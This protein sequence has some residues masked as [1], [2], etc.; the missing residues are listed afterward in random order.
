MPINGAYCWAVE[1]VARAGCPSA[2]YAELTAI[3]RDE[4]VIEVVPGALGPLAPGRRARL[5]FTLY[6]QEASIL[7]GRLTRL[8]C[9]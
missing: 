7:T 6:G 2:V 4:R 1:L 3:D 5:T 9:Y 8:E